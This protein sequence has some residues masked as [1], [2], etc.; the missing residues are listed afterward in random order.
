MI[1]KNGG[2]ITH[3]IN[4]MYIS[5][6]LHTEKICGIRLSAAMMAAMKE[7]SKDLVDDP[8]WATRELKK[9][10][11]VQVYLAAPGQEHISFDYPDP[12]APGEK[13]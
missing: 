7:E 8:E 4:A 12:P 1:I 6:A 2:A 9:F 5:Q 3:L 13:P 11:G 10:A